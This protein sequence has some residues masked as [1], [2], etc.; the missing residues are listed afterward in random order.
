MASRVLSGDTQNDRGQGGSRE[1]SRV[2]QEDGGSWRYVPQGYGRYDAYV[3]DRFE[4][5]LEGYMMNYSQLSEAQFNDTHSKNPLQRNVVKAS[6]KIKEELRKRGVKVT[7]QDAR[8]A[9][10]SDF[11]KAISEAVAQNPNGWMVDVHEEFSYE[12]CT[13]FLTEDGKSGIAVTPDG[14]IISL[15]SSVQRDHR[16]ELLMQLAILAGGRKL[17]CYYTNTGGTISGLPILY[18]K[19]RFKVAVNYSFCYC[20]ILKM[21]HKSINRS[22]V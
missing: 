14:N 12:V 13:C 9:T 16:T 2:Y 15:F 21:L 19:F 5:F 8:L 3:E 11:H 18:S 6:Y 7:S 20:C 4:R 10:A 1:G 17:D 22:V